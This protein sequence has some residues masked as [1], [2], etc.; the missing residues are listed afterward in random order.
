MPADSGKRPREV[1]LPLDAG[2]G[3]SL[4]PANGCLKS[5][6][7]ICRGIGH[8]ATLTPQYRDQSPY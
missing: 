4:K 7:M 1:Q 8:V 5:L 2:R 6:R 3:L